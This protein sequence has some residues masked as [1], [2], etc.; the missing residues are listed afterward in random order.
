MKQKNKSNK[1]E[2]NISELGQFGSLAAGALVVYRSIFKK[3]SL[4]GSAI[5][6]YLLYRGATG[7]CAV[8]DALNINTAKK[9]GSI[10]VKTTITV[11]K[12][13]AEVYAFWK[14]LENLPRFMKHLESV[15]VV[16][17]KHSEW[18]A[19]I[20][21]GLGTIDW[22]SE[23]VADEKN[24]SLAW[25]SVEGSE[26]DNSGAVSFKDAG[27]FGTEVHVEIA[28][29]APAGHLGKGIAELLNPITEGM[30]K[31]DIKNFRRIIESEELPTIDGQASGKH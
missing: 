17:K 5:G 11:N 4:T 18:K 20:P 16:D 13:K 22:K 12:P 6:A 2:Q 25:K 7:Y 21:G 26:V 31:E 3:R 24:E 23:I 19:K 14:K 28:Y 8:S 15:E 9:P 30:I 1:Q 27:K 10:L 29:H